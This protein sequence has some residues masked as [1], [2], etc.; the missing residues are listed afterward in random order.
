M[1]DFFL[2]RLIKSEDMLRSH[3]F[4]VEVAK[5]AIEVSKG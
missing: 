2:P 4:Y 1:L 5:K 3:R